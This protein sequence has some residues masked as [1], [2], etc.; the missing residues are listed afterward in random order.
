MSSR[1]GPR[2]DRSTRSRT[3]P[4]PVGFP[5]RRSLK[6]FPEPGPRQA[7]C[8]RAPRSVRPLTLPTSSEEPRQRRPR[9]RPRLGLDRIGRAGG[10]HVQDR[11]TKSPISSSRSAGSSRE[12]RPSSMCTSGGRGWCWQDRW[13]AS[14]QGAKPV[15]PGPV[16]FAAYI[17]ASAVW[18]SSNASRSSTASTRATPVLAVTVGVVSLWWMGMAAAQ[19]SWSM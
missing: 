13:W 19:C 7:G 4:T 11:P 1:V 3:S 6:S 16:A 15:C 9:P 2:S 17:A 10:R 12:K 8:T 14:R 5:S 18:S